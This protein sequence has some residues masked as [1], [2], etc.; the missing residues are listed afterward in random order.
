VAGGLFYLLWR[1]MPQ[2]RAGLD[3]PGVAQLLLVMTIVSA[4][5]VR[6]R[7][8]KPLAI[9]GGLAAW[10]GIVLV[11]IVGWALRDDFPEMALKIRTALAP[12]L[13]VRA[14]PRELVVGRSE[15]STFTLTGQVNGAPVRFVVDTGA[16]DVVLS[17]DDARRAGLNLAELRFDRPSITANGVGYGAHAMVDNLTLGP[18][19]LTHVPVTVNKAPMFASL[20]GATVLS[21]LDSFEVRGDRMILRG[22]P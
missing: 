17:P 6:V 15:D 7:R 4:G 2:E 14:G 18:I 16:T 22:K 19:R 12:G 10:A 21:R 1:F 5:V 9:L 3:W 11:L 20:L 13:A 8:M